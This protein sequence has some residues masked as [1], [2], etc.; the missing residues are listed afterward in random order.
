MAS[1]VNIVVNASDKAAVAT[2]DELKAR[3]DEI[4][5][6]NVAASVNLTGDA[7]RKADELTVK[8]AE[9]S[10]K[11][12]SPRI[13]VV[14]AEKSRLAIDA[15]ELKM[16]ELGSESKATSTS[17]SSM[18]AP[19]GGFGALIA[20]G[21]VLSPMIA[22]LGT[23]LAG[24]GL[25]AVGVA[26]PIENAA[27]KTGGLSANMSKLNPEQQKV[28]QGLLGLGQ[29]YDKFQH[30]MQP[31]VFTV[32]NAG[33]KLAGGL[34]HDIEPVAKATG[35]A[36]GG[37]IGQI[38]AEFKSGT[39]QQFFGFM[40][41][42]AGPDMQQLGGLFT[43]ILQDLPPLIEGLQPLAQALIGVATD[44]TSVIGGL[45]KF[46]LSLPILG[47]TIGAFVGG[48]LGALV[49]GLIGAGTEAF[50]AMNKVQTSV[51]ATIP[52]W[53]KS[54][55]ATQFAIK[56]L[57]GFGP[58]IA[59]YVQW[60]HDTDQAGKNSNAVLQQYGKM[61]ATSG[62]AAA[63]A[64]PKFFSLDKAVNALSASM[65]KLIGNLLQLQGSE[66]SWKQALQA[67]ETQVKSNT[68]GLEGN[69]KNAL[70]NKQA[71]LQATNAA[72]T[73]AQQEL[74]TGKDITGASDTIQR[75]IRWLQSLHDKSSFVRDE[76]E[77]LRK[78][79]KLL[80]AQRINQMI[81]VEGLGQWQVSQ[82]LAPGSG[83]RRARGGLIPGSGGGD[84]YPALLTPGELVVPRGMVAAGAVDHLR[85]KLPGFAGGGIVPSFQGDPGGLTPWVK[86]NDA[87]TI[88]LMDLAVVKATVA[89]I[90]AAEAAARSN[91][92]G[93]PGP[94]GGAPAANAALARRMMTD[95]STGANWAAW[96]YVA[97]RESGWN[98]FA[99][100]PSS[101]AYGIPQALPPSKMGPAANPPQSNP[102]AQI[103]WM[104]GYMQSRYGGPIGAAAHERA[105]NW[106][107]H[108]GF[109]PPGLSLSYN[110]T[111]RPEMVM[112][113]GGMNIHLVVDAGPGE[114]SQFLAKEIRKYVRIHG[115]GNVQ[116][117]FG[118]T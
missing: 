71:V 113:P 90:R 39:W 110:G 28:A 92:F 18:A 79:E 86:G 75:Q 73:Y 38:D 13:D 19:G 87:A 15:V 25:A 102:A 52:A 60:L 115:G 83:H 1:V 7:K 116:Q 41:K 80:A 98:Q 55:Q 34:L 47:A 43:G 32:F 48:P 26:K 14:G 94:G 24:F 4:G 82:S 46:H 109:L 42:T 63:A 10:K 21:A 104:I 20:A 45:N 8:L 99:R 50:N 65:T 2:L 91:Q 77:A 101:G 62:S 36:L 35:N 16:A 105:F 72:L 40:A 84:S 93:A 95:W 6:K 30:D 68:A 59:K 85:G 111:G 5:R 9:L 53:T 12:A 76:L 81:H 107:D 3:I 33:L 31:A 54:A 66:L 17:L 51:N 112:P 56:S 97:M 100:N 118:R 74:T 44:L 67:A 69:S 78:E 27:Q 70:A 57:S 103:S 11:V 64:G 58:Q 106:Y 88:R 37:M 114:Y 29:Q 49:G 108:G 61:L 22:T 96:N 117:A 23:G 89:G